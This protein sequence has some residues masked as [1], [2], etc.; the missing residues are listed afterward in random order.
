MPNK[1]I[2]QIKCPKRKMEVDKYEVNLTSGLLN[3]TWLLYDLRIY[4]GKTGSSQF[5]AN[6]VKLN[7]GMKFKIAVIIIHN[8]NQ[9]KT[10]VDFHPSSWFWCQLCC[11]CVVFFKIL[12]IFIQP[13]I[14][15]VT[16][17]CDY[18]HNLSR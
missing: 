16:E 13:D 15:G 11:V 18:I 10:N 1:S 17:Q 14:T 4:N 5:V 12:R 7:L 2:L 8:Q 6:F 9:C 3:T